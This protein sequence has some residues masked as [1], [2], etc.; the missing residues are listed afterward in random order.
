MN[1]EKTGY[2]PHVQGLRGIAVLAVVL[3]HSGLPLHGGYLGVDI[4]F[5]ISGYVVTLSIKQQITDNRFSL[6]DFYSRRIRRLIPL[7]TLVNVVTIALCVF[8][9][10]LFGEIQKGLSTVRW[11]S[12]FGANIQLLDENSYT[13]LTRNPFR[14][15]WSL[16]V[17]EQFYFIYPIVAIAAIQISKWTNKID[18][19]AWFGR[20]FLVLF[21]I[22]F[23]FY[24]LLTKNSLSE[25][26]LKYAFF[27]ITPR[28]W[29]FA[30]GVLIAVY[31]SNLKKTAKPLT[32]FIRY[33]AA[34]SLMIVLS[35]LHSNHQ[36][37]RAILV[38]PVAATTGMILFGD[39]GRLGKLLASRPLTYLGDV[40]YGWYLWHWPLIVFTS[41]IFP[42][43]IAAAI[44][45]SIF[46]LLLS[47]VTYQQIEKPFRRNFKIRGLKAA[48]VLIGSILVINL[49]VTGANAIGKLAREKLLPIDQEW[50]GNKNN[51]LEQ[52]FLGEKYVTWVFNNPKTISDLCSWPNK[53]S[54]RYPIF[55]IGDSHM[56]SYSGGLMTGASAIGSEITL[57]G[58]AGCPPILAPPKASIQFCNRMSAAYINAIIA[59]RPSVIILSGRTSLYTSKVK[60]F[61]G[62][63]M[64]VPFLDGTYPTDTSDFIDSYM[65]QLD[66]T[67]AFAIKYGSKVIIT[68]EPQQA[69]LSSQSLIQHYF[70]ELVGDPNSD[71]A[72]RIKTRELIKL[73]INQRFSTNPKVLIFDPEDVLCADR[74]YCLAYR[75]NEP[76]Y[77]DD[78]HLSMAGSLL[79][80]EKWKQILEQA[81]DQTG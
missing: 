48:A 32:P 78:N 31:S 40:S 75:D 64:Q 59:F 43:N 19:K 1:I 27:S 55:A 6:G 35:L 61:D 2:V 14:H 5:V 23:I 24:L 26:N 67:V 66:R 36:L 13:K 71:S 51:V 15:L 63:K 28:F 79:F 69:Q 76:M 74:N 12:F 53:T 46:A 33:T 81:L 80:T 38:I 77:S 60:A 37:P 20:L 72:G 34:I 17:E 42:G 39:T 4:F 73:S 8:F 62:I 57:Y 45:V 68:L 29:E 7:L 56:A 18:W 52:C 30:S 41:I 44:A 21:V 9:L 3:Y 65:D 10:S 58:A 25:S 54:N 47:H 22:S 70:P 49:S 50:D 16:A 11:S